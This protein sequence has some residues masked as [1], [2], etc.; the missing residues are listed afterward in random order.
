M[1][2]AAPR[3]HA[4]LAADAY[5]AVHAAL[6]YLD[7]AGRE[8]GPATDAD[9]TEADALDLIS[10]AAYGC[11]VYAAISAADAA[12]EPCLPWA[13]FEREANRAIDRAAHADDGDVTRFQL[14]THSDPG[15]LLCMPISDW[16][17]DQEDDVLAYL[18]SR[19]WTADLSRAYARYVSLTLLPLTDTPLPALPRA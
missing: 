16:Y 15:R 8:H 5:A 2:A 10:A 3:T 13:A 4:T 9:P 6:T 1:T 7:T 18:S 19:T 11:G 17:S 12:A 14:V